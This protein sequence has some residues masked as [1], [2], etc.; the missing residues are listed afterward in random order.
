MAQTIK[1]SAVNHGGRKST[2]TEE[3]RSHPRRGCLPDPER[4]QV[5][6]IISGRGTLGILCFSYKKCSPE[7]MQE[8]R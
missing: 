7:R 4:H 5:K 3:D 6:S 8:E 2:S 1:H